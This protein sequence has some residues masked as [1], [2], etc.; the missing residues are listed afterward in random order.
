MDQKKIGLFL[1]MLRNEK[2]LTQEQLAEKLNVSNRSVSRWETGSTLPDISLIIE[3]ADYYEV[4]IKELV[5]GER[6]SEIMNKELTETFDKI[7]EYSIERKK[8][9]LQKDG[10]FTEILIVIGIIIS[11]TLAK[12]VA[13]NTAQ[14]IVTLICGWFVWG[15]GIVLR[16][17]IR[18]ELNE[19]T[20]R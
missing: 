10:I 17:K 9:Q 12:F 16:V 6:K 18:K 7:A 15:Y 11:F 8:S 2:G 19:L 5:E 20:K 14:L 1:K 13:D 4:D 3:L